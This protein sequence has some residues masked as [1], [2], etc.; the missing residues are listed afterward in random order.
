[1]SS[2]IFF[3]LQSYTVFSTAS[4]ILICFTGCINIYLVLIPTGKKAYLSSARVLERVM[5]C[6]FVSKYYFK[7]RHF[8]A[9]VEG[10][11]L[12]REALG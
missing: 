4:D 5:T 10:T 7:F 2:N 6:F 9:D 12:I 1:M 3:K 11:Y 8:R